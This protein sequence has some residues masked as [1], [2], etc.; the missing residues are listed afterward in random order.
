MAAKSEG[1]GRDRAEARQGIDDM[2]RIVQSVELQMAV[3]DAD[4][5]AERNDV[6][7]VPGGYYTWRLVPERQLN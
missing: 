6:E 7:E 1:Q 2:M 4:G 5:C 3:N